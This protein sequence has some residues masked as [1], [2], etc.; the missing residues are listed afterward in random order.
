M[1]THY[2]YLSQYHLGG[3]LVID[4]AAYRPRKPHDGKMIVIGERRREWIPVE[5]CATRNEAHAAAK[6]ILEVLEALGEGPPQ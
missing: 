4:A 5:D 6:E 3:D 2:V 1:I